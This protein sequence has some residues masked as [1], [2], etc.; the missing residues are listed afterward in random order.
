MFLKRRSKRKNKRFN[1]HF[2]RLFISNS[3]TFVTCPAFYQVDALLMSPI[4]QSSQRP[5]VYTKEIF[6]VRP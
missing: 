5:K 1:I 6:F 2:L 4:E 3:R